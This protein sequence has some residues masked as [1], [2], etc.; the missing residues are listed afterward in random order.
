MLETKNSFLI[1]TVTLN[2]LLVYGIPKYW[3]EKTFQKITTMIDCIRDTMLG[4]ED[5]VFT[6]SLLL[7]ALELVIK[8]VFSDQESL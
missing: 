4:E 2:L 8:V 6:R 3:A 7:L 5:R 1:W